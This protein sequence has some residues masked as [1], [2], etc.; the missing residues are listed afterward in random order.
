MSSSAIPA[1]SF[2]AA[3][4]VRVLLREAR[5]GALATL[6]ADGAPY[7]SL[8][9]VATASDGAPVLLL[10]SLA[11]HTRNLRAD[12]RVSLLVD[13]RRAGE[14][15]QGAR[16]SIG[17]TIA[18]TEDEA[19][20]RRFL[21]RHPDSAGFAGFADFAFYRIEPKAAHLVAGFGRIVDVERGAILT[22]I[23]DAQEVVAAEAS[24]VEHMNTD[25]ADAVAAYATVLLG[26]PA[27]DWRLI[28]VDPEG[29]ELMA[30]E[31]VRRL[32]FG[33]RITTAEDLHRIMVE[34]ARRTRA[35]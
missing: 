22:P 4:A 6:D 33:R 15:L 34:L 2:D 27:G 1:E 25:H 10:S 19:V 29:C 30:G 20:R 12:S 8:V 17:G 13:E 23:G 5:M 3:R 7:V 14:E 28:G 31:R 18:K 9:Q 24:A 11:R 26:A 35:A 32:D 16:A 21:M